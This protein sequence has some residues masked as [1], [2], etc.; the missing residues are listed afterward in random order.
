MALAGK[1]DAM[2][3]VTELSDLRRPAL[4]ELRRV[5]DNAPVTKLGFVLTGAPAEESYYGYGGA[6]NGAASKRRQREQVT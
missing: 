1:V 6:S 4:G 3:V 2:V 5:L